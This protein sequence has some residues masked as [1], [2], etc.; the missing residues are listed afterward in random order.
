MFEK[1]KSLI[2]QFFRRMEAFKDY[3]SAIQLY[4]KLQKQE[5]SLNIERANKTRD[6]LKDVIMSAHEGITRIYNLYK[7]AYDA[8]KKETA[9]DVYTKKES[10][11]YFV[12][13]EKVYNNIKE[14]KSEIVDA[15][16]E[17]NKRG[18]AKIQ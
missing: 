18:G 14:M 7:P 10:E 16:K 9:T 2:M 11:A 8:I 3:N 12:E 13:L 6:E 5:R 17:M 4:E 1:K 15:D